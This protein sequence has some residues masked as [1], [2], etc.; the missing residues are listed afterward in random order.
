[1]NKSLLLATFALISSSA[2]AQLVIPGQRYDGGKKHEFP[3][4][5]LSNG[6]KVIHLSSGKGA[7][8][9]EKSV[10]QVLYQGTFVDGKV[11]DTSAKP[12]E[13]ALKGVIPCWTTGLQKLKVREVAK[14]ECPAETAYGSKGVPG[15]I[16][17]NTPL[18]F[19]VQL[20]AI[21]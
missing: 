20:L 6:V 15:V 2:F 7:T 4:D 19:T 17:P 11:F 21:K 10:V 8:P 12:V 16:P 13:F 5:V 1:M 3:I 18:R 9:T 14:L